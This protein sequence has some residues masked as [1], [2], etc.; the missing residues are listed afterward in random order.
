[1]PVVEHPDAFEATGCTG[2]PSQAR[3]AVALAIDDSHDCL[4]TVGRP[5]DNAAMNMLKRLVVP[6]VG[7]FLLVGCANQKDME[8]PMAV[9]EVCIISGEPVDADS[10][11]S[12]FMGHTVRFCCDRCKGKFDAMDDEAKKA[13]MD[14]K[15]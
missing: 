4:A 13:A 12:E 2:L 3:S 8:A 5:I 9:D 1:M 7:A 6:M 10:P 11:T 14:T 15:D